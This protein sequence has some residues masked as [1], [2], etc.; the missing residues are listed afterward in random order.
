ML[1]CARH[2]SQHFQ[3]CNSNT[4][5]LVLN[6]TPCIRYCCCPRFPAV[7]AQEHLCPAY[8]HRAGQG[9]GALGRDDIRFV[10]I[11][12]QKSCQSQA[13]ACYVDPFVLFFT[14]ENSNK[15]TE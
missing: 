8:L 14:L 9:L 7:E 2:S 4:L 5:D 11:S 13:Q 15:N 10:K 3:R 1:L 6:V 12:H